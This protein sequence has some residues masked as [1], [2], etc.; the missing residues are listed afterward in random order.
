MRR[1]VHRGRLLR[2]GRVILQGARALRARVVVLRPGSAIDWHSTKAKE[3]L[4]IVLAGRVRLEVKGRAKS[5]GHRMLPRGS[6]AFVPEQTWHRVV[7][8]SRALAKYLYVTA[9]AR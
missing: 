1:G 9:P 4:L 7:S 3:E 5:V 6:Y 2:S 8:A